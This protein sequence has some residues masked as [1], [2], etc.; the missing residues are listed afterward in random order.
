MMGMTDFIYWSSTFLN[1]F[2]V[3]AVVCLIITFIYKVPLKGG[4]IV[5]ENSNFFV[6]FII[7]LLFMANLTLFSL[8]LTTFFNKGKL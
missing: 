2:V 3:G 1:Y 4:V 8:A 7:L 5:L 6:L